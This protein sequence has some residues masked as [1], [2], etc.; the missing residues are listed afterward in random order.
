VNELEDRS[1]DLGTDERTNER[2]PT[3]EKTRGENDHAG[4]VDK[5][6]MQAR[7]HKLASHKSYTMIA[8]DV[9]VLG[10][11]PVSRL[12]FSSRSLIIQAHNNKAKDAFVKKTDTEGKKTGQCVAAIKRARARERT[13]CLRTQTRCSGCFQPAD[14]GTGLVS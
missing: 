12:L 14:C 11:V 13:G 7:C 10:M 1:R 4:Q 6:R 5:P 8:R 3:Q 2:I 9:M